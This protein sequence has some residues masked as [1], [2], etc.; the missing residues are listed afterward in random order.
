MKAEGAELFFALTQ[1]GRCFSGHAPDVSR[2]GRYGAGYGSH[3]VNDL[4]T[5]ILHAVWILPSRDLQTFTEVGQ[6]LCIAV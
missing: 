2:G 1:V 4:Q 6:G 3:I 5:R